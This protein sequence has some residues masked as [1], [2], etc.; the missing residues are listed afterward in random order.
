ME[1]TPHAP[2]PEPE[3]G[4][5][6]HTHTQTVEFVYVPFFITWRRRRLCTFEI[7]SFNNV[8]NAVLY[9]YRSHSFFSHMCVLAHWK[10]SREERDA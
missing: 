3:P 9:F 6:I 10:K 1:P 4:T 2:E 8:K 5:N 7:D